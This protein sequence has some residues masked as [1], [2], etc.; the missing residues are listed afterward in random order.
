MKTLFTTLALSVALATPAL[1]QTADRTE[2]LAQYQ[3]RTYDNRA[4]DYNAFAREPDVRVIPRP[5]PSIDRRNDV[6]GPR[7]E[8]LGSDPDPRIRDQ[9]R[10]DPGQGKDD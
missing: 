5:G 9:M 6:Y 10:R 1:S 3:P 2:Q 8:Y 4:S 7:G